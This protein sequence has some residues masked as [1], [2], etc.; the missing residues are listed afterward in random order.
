MLPQLKSFVVIALSFACLSLWLL[1]L[2]A[3]EYQKSKALRGADHRVT[4]SLLRDHKTAVNVFLFLLLVTVA[5]VETAFIY[6][7]R[8]MGPVTVGW[9][10]LAHAVSDAVLVATL[11]RMRF[12]DTGLRN[13]K[14]HTWLKTYVLYPS[15]ASMALTGSILLYRL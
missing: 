10:F 11:I 12:F 3:R 4:Q 2:V 14:R 7:V 5:F 6:R 13:P 15:F 1:T 8:T 9:I